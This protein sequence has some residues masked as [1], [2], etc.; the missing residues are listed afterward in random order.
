M[1]K[2]SLHSF[3][4]IEYN[5]EQIV[6]DIAFNKPKN[7]KTKSTQWVYYKWDPACEIILENGNII[8]LRIWGKHMAENQKN[9]RDRRV[10]ISAYISKEN[11][12]K[13]HLSLYGWHSYNDYEW[14]WWI[15]LES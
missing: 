7:I 12:V 8:T 3:E 11:W 2:N 1:V 9:K 13:S 5:Y 4:T 15:I 6:Q 10:F 14:I